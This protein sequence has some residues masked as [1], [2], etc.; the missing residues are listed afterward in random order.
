MIFH[1]AEKLVWKACEKL[2]SYVPSEYLEEGFVHCSEFSQVEKT[3][4]NYYQGRDD[5]VLLAIDP[6]KLGAETRYE[7]LIG[8]EEKFPHVYGELLKVA[9]TKVV[10]LKWN[11]DNQLVGLA[12]FN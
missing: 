3:A 8:G 10:D 7:N 6:E 4:K 9:I 1:I 5:L 11:K 12:E 2:D